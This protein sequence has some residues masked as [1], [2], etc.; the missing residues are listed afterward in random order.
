[1]PAA[2]LAILF[3][4]GCGD[5]GG[6][7]PGEPLP[8]VA[9]ERSQTTDIGAL[10][11]VAPPPGLRRRDRDGDG[12]QEDGGGPVTPTVTATPTAVST[13]VPTPPRPTAT[14]QPTVTFEPEG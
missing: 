7:A 12:E 6:E 14:P 10:P 9:V 3:L 11:T 5:E 8:R 13:P 2:V 4:A 1:M